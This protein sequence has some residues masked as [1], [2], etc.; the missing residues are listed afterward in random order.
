MKTQWQIYK[1]LELLPDSLSA[2]SERKFTG[3][4]PL[5]KVWQ[6]LID[7]FAKKLSDQQ[8]VEHLERSF[9]RDCSFSPII[10]WQIIWTF[11]NQ[12][13]FVPSLSASSEPQIWTTLEGDGNI[14]W[15]VYDPMTGQKN[16]LG[17]E[18][19]VLIW[20]EEHLNS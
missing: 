2:P 17:S 15:H 9:A 20:L 8:Q 19:E 3:V 13:L 14:W 6:R 1:E 4:T 18:Q 11:L 7:A 5:G 16:V 12:P 10:T